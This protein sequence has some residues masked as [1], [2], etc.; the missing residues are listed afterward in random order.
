MPAKRTVAKK[1][2]PPKRSAPQRRRLSTA[3]MKPSKSLS[4]ANY[5]V[6]HLLPTANSSPT[7]YP[8]GDV[9]EKI[10]IN[11]AT[12][13]QLTVP[14]AASSTTGQ[15]VGITDIERIA[16]PNTNPDYGT[17]VQDRAGE[18]IIAFLPGSIRTPIFLEVGVVSTTDSTIRSLQGGTKSRL[19]DNIQSQCDSYRVTAATL[20]LIYTGNDYDNGGEICV[21]KFDPFDINYY[22]TLD[23]IGGT[24][25]LGSVPRTIDTECKARRFLPAKHGLNM[26]F[27]RSH[28]DGF[29]TYKPTKQ[30]TTPHPQT[31]AAVSSL[32]GCV[33]RISGCATEAPQ[34][35]RWELVQTVELVPRPGTL[36]SI[37]GKPSDLP[38]QVLD[39]IA[40]KT[41]A[42][43]TKNG[44]D[45]TSH[46]VNQRNMCMLTAQR[47]AG[48]VASELGGSLP[49]PPSSSE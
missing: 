49:R 13:G 48:P 12:Q 22:N 15:Q 23:V 40:L 17:C 18:N 46:H 29:H 35:W 16:I 44:H 24:D 25:Y 38:N 19:Y 26:T 34:L 30:Q 45:I 32:E 10:T 47:N 36:L 27:F 1:R 31:D 3:P 2:A 11:L 28:R 8:G 33:I 41:A 4:V 42:D 39:S 37:L 7:G 5:V 20:K 9:S 6:N 21:Q 14:T 43:C